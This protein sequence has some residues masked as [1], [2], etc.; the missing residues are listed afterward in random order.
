[1][2]NQFDITSGGPRARAPSL[3]YDALSL[4]SSGVNAK[5]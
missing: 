3:F 4:L 5:L 1:M 2:E